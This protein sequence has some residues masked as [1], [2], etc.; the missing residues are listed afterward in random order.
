MS[1]TIRLVA[2]ITIKEGLRNRAMQGVLT[3]AL[4]LCLVYITI[5]PMFAFDT[6]KVV[7]D[8]GFAFVTLA[9]LAIVIF[10]GI[11]LLTADIHQRTVCM[12]LSRPV[13]RTDYVVGKYCGLA[14]TVLLAVLMIAALTVFTS[15]IGIKLI[16][17]MKLP[18][19]FS[20][21]I[22]R[23]GVSVPI[24]LLVDAHGGRFFLCLPDHQRIPL[25]AFH[26]LRLCHRQQPG[27]R[28][29]SHPGRSI[30][31]SW[32]GISGTAEG[33]ILAFSQFQRIR[34]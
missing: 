33:D 26:T 29:R 16:P 12:I 8:L 31:P 23:R 18:R 5:I 27:N 3:I 25:H 11:A 20:W 19:N 28:H 34:F 14:V 30:R 4:M 13:S 15:W 32:D 10:L 7:V 2:A 21:G 1:T 9:G 22:L 17:E 24:S 6:G